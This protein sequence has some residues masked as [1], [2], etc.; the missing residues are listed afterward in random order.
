MAAQLEQWRIAHQ[1]NLCSTAF[2][3]K[4]EVIEL[5]KKIFE[6]S[7]LKDGS[8]LLLHG[9]KYDVISFTLNEASALVS[10]TAVVDPFKDWWMNLFGD[11]GDN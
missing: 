6:Q 9:S 10:V 7:F 11:Q 1:A 5:S 8:V 2:S 4:V 3:E